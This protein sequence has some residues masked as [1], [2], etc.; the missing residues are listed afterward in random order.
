MRFPK[1]ISHQLG[2]AVLKYKW[3]IFFYV[4][5]VYFILPLI[6]FGL[7]LIPYWIGL[8]IFVLPFVLL[9]LFVLV[10]FFIQSWLPKILPDKLKNFDWLPVW[11]RSLEP[12]DKVIK[13]LA[14]TCCSCRKKVKSETETGIPQVETVDE[15]TLRISEVIRRL[16]VVEGIVNEARVFSRRNSLKEIPSEDEEDEYYMNVLKVDEKKN[17]SHRNSITSENYISRF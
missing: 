5:S 14:R 17:I 11:M 3:F 12:L 13:S 7:A 15:T 2:K 8:A 10:I 6:V 16:S 1:R 9:I 4:S